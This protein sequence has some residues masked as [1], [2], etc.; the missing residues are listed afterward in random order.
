MTIEAL[1]KIAIVY[2]KTKHLQ[3]VAVCTGAIKEMT[4]F[5]IDSLWQHYSDPHYVCP[6]LH[7]CQK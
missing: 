1:I 6:K 2:C 4:P 3:D 7:F 5:L